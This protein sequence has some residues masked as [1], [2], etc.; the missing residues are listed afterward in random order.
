MLYR[1][2]KAHW[3]DRWQRKRSFVR[4]TSTLYLQ[5][6]FLD[7]YG[8]Q[9]EHIPHAPYLPSY[10]DGTSPFDK[11]TAVYMGNFYPAW[12]HDIILEAAAILKQRNI[13][14]AILLMGDGPD[15]EKWR[16]FV[17]EKGLTNV[18]LPGYVSGEELWRRLRHAHVLLFPI[19]DTLINRTRCPSKVF[20]YAQAR[21][22][23]ITSR[24]GELPYMLGQDKPI[25]IESTPQAFADAIADAMSKPALAD[26]EYHLENHS[27]KDRV[28]RLLKAIEEAESRARA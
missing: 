19:R 13:T 2:M 28:D 12:D 15:M 11:P 1:A 10:A 26:V 25:Y 24:V 5:Q 21:R 9:T 23:I 27:W 4:I 6:L 3:P 16:R 7:R 8:L 22:P 17:A 20:A 18:Q 14:P